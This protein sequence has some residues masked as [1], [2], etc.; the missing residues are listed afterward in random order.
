MAR[1]GGPV[2]TERMETRYTIGHGPV[3]VA[4]FLREALVVFG[5]V[6]GATTG[7]RGMGVF[8]REQ[9]SLGANV[10]LHAEGRGVCTPGGSPC[11]AVMDDC[12]HGHRI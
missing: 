11:V 12:V 10:R 2:R 5:K 8:A 7:V 3:M 6:S 9:W 1:G 4:V